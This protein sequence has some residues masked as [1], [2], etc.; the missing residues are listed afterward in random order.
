MYIESARAE[1]ARNSTVIAYCS[2]QIRRR[3]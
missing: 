3:R 1:T 2:W